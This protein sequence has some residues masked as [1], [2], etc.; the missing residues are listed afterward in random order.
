[1]VPNLL[2]TL[3][4]GGGAALDIR[5]PEAL[6]FFSE[7]GAGDRATTGAVQTALPPCRARRAAVAQVAAAMEAGSR[8]EQAT[9]QAPAEPEPTRARALDWRRL[10]RPAAL[11][12]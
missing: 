2:T 9:E 8:P 5:Q 11:A 4:Q 6:P 1:M 10:M 7:F 12:A 3:T